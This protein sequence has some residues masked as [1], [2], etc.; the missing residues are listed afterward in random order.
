[1]NDFSLT[2]IRLRA[3]Q[4]AGASPAAISLML[5]GMDNGDWF[6]A[7]KKTAMMQT[8]IT[9]RKQWEAATRELA[10]WGCY[11]VKYYKSN[12]GTPRKRIFFSW[13]N[14]EGVHRPDD[15]FDV[16]DDED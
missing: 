5:W 8:G 3:M 4:R 10:K 11:E 7:R 1:M 15:T 14:L 12:T 2:T 16:I 6:I 13:G 9:N